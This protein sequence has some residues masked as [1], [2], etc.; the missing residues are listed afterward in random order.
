MVVELGPYPLCD[1]CRRTNGGLVAT[2]HRQVHVSVA[3]QEACVDQGLA[4]VIA[5][6]WPLCS[7]RACCEDDDGRAYVV[8]TADTANAAESALVALGLDVERTA[9]GTLRFTLPAT[10]S[11]TV[12]PD[13]SVDGDF[14][15]AVD[16]ARRAVAEAAEQLGRH[17]VGIEHPR[18][19]EARNQLAAAQEWL[20]VAMVRRVSVFR[21]PSGTLRPGGIVLHVGLLAAAC[22]GAASAAGFVAGGSTAWT[23]VGGV[24]GVIAVLVPIMLLTN[25]L[26][27]RVGRWTVAR[28][29]RKRGEAAHAEPPWP[30]VFVPVDRALV[31]IRKSVDA[32]RRGVAEIAERHMRGRGHQPPA[33]P[34]FLAYQAFDFE[35]RATAEADLALCQA[36]DAIRIWLEAPQ[37]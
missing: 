29:L 32:V 35:T 34:V 14:L 9:D 28:I 18:V 8:P 1:R 10:P 2:R 3:G 19:T 36:S 27:N 20:T 13:L 5:A 6:L 11:R 4:G 12:R 37:G 21:G 31:D 25:F 7:T 22:W 33:A 17:T 15:V 16:V 30:G 24:A 26:E 23:L